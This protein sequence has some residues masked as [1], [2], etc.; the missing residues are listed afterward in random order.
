MIV[1][2]DTDD[3]DGSDDDD[4]DDDDDDNDDD[5]DDNYDEGFS[6]GMNVIGIYGMN[7][8]LIYDDYQGT[9]SPPVS[10]AIGYVT[11]RG[12]DIG[13]FALGEKADYVSV[14]AH[15]YIQFLLDSFE[16]I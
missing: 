4:D 13:D 10:E 12:S 7:S 15:S 9:T 16:D 2:T 8:R 1:A 6:G 3:V 14:A 11:R 5:D